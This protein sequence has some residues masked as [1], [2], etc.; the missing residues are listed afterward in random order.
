MS[1]FP[2]GRC[3]TQ[4]NQVGTLEAPKKVSV[5]LSVCVGRSFRVTAFTHLHFRVT[6]SH[7][8]A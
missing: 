6:Y 7:G 1:L 8:V 2:L 3:R 5:F 4:G